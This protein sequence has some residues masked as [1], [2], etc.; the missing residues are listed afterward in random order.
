MIVS[1]HTCEKLE[2]HND[3]D[4]AEVE[5]EMYTSPSFNMSVRTD[6]GWTVQL[7]IIYCPFCGEKLVKE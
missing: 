4:F 1:S 6:D 3:T 7:P 2:H 5:I